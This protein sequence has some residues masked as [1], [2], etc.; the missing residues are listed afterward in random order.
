MRINRFVTIAV[1]ALVLSAL[2]VRS[3]VA[4]Q[5]A[6]IR[7]E[8]ARLTPG[9]PATRSNDKPLGYQ[10]CLASDAEWT[11]RPFAS[12]GNPDEALRRALVVLG[13]EGWELVSAI[14]ETE[15][16]SY[17][18]GLTYLLKRQKSQ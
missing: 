1:C 12:D 11:C 15:Q 2:T 8:Y 17:P 6:P 14:D 5:A 10:A 4:R 16:L 9:L 3:L 13:A 7:W 18:K